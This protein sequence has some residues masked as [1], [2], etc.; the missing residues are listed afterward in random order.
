[1]S[2]PQVVVEAYQTPLLKRLL[3]RPQ[4]FR[5]R[6]YNARNGRVLGV[7][8]EAYTNEADMHAAIRQLFGEGSEV[9]L[10][11]GA[12]STVLRRAA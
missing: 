2:V 10:L 4:R 5:W 8:S 7:S 9:R 3:G 11:Q 6:A 12:A 1:M